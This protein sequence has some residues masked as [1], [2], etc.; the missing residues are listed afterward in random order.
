[1]KILHYL[2]G[3]SMLISGI[4]L[5]LPVGTGSV[6][7]CPRCRR[8]LPKGP[9]KQPHPGFPDRNRHKNFLYVPSVSP[10]IAQAAVAKLPSSCSGSC[11]VQQKTFS[12]TFSQKKYEGA[13]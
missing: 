7:A 2:L 4:D 9:R 5:I 12:S 3:A 11:C 1:M 6:Y 10:S 8:A 13:Q